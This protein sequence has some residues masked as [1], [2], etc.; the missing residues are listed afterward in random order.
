MYC[1]PT[2]L[3]ETM[4]KVNILFKSS[5]GLSSKQEQKVVNSFE[6][7]VNPELLTFVNVHQN[8]VDKVYD[9]KRSL[10][11]G[12]LKVIKIALWI[13]VMVH[14][15]KTASCS[16]HW[17]SL[18]FSATLQEK[19]WKVPLYLCRTTV[20]R[21]AQS[22]LPSR[23]LANI[24]L[25]WD[26]YL[27]ESDDKADLTYYQN[28]EETRSGFNKFL[29]TTTRSLLCCTLSRSCALRACNLA[30]KRGG[31]S[32]KSQHCSLI[33]QISRDIARDADHGILTWLNIV[34][35]S[36]R[37]WGKIKSVASIPERVG[38][39]YMVIIKLPEKMKDKWNPKGRKQFWEKCQ[40]K[41]AWVWTTQ[42]L[43]P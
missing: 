11:N 9:S 38:W 14:I 28:P 1:N 26:L 4:C 31:V 7:F 35:V 12:K 13:I 15:I 36:P 40:P 3:A 30:G 8:F 2:R 18:D 32:W 6:R 41:R 22:K 16:A 20:H 39:A 42:S 33:K 5:C 25:P 29:S 17:R 10:T 23:T 19:N 34:N 37:R 43:S 24:V 21:K 27:P